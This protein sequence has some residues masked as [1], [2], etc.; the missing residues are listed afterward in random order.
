MIKLVVIVVLGGI[1]LLAEAGAD[2][3]RLSQDELGAVYRIE[4]TPRGAAAPLREEDEVTVA[5]LQLWRHDGAVAHEFPALGIVDIWYRLAGERARPTR[6]FDE[7]QRAIAHPPGTGGGYAWQQQYRIVD[8]AMLR[9]LTLQ[10]REG[11]GCDTVETYYQ[12]SGEREIYLQ[13]L[14]QLQLVRLLRDATATGMT[15]W[16][17]QA[18]D[19]DAGRV[20]AVFAQ[21]AGY[22]VSNYSEIVA[23]SSDPLL[24]QLVGFSAFRVGTSGLFDASSAGL[25]R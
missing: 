22:Q 7:H 10:K 4:F 19:T 9:D 23:G 5:T 14:P 18:T 15:E 16:R 25:Q 17:L 3:C 6:F 13:W 24:L 1:A 2:P 8:A 12:Q 21:R 11:S 20:A